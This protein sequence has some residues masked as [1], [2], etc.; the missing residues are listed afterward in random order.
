M[1]VIGAHWDTVPGSP[2]VGDNGSG[3]AALLEV[4]FNIAL[5][6]LIIDK[7]DSYLILATLLEVTLNMTLNALIKIITISIIKKLNCIFSLPD[8][9]NVGDS[10]GGDQQLCDRGCL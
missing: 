5:K 6:Y 1:T 8:N 3:L 2:G 7:K 9:K 4:T 10:E